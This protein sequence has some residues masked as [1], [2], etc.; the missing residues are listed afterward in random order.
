[1][2]DEHNWLYIVAVG[3]HIDDVEV[4]PPVLEEIVDPEQLAVTET[5]SGSQLGQLVGNTELVLMNEV[6]VTV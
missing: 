3:E 6:K 1:M 4:D 2:L 5:V